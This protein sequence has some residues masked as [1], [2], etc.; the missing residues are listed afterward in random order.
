MWNR[1]K[2]VANA[3]KG[4][5]GG[6]TLQYGLTSSAP[7]QPFGEEFGL[8]IIPMYLSSSETSSIRKTVADTLSRKSGD[9]KVS[10]GRFQLPAFPKDVVLPIV[11][12][13]ERQD[14]VPSGWL[15]NQTANLYQQGDFIRSHVDNL[16]VYDDVFAIAS[17]GCNCL[18]KFVHVQNGEELE[19]VIPDGS[20]YILSG[21][22]RYVYF[23]M[24][25]PCEGQRI[26]LVM[27]RSILQSEGT[28]RVTNN[29]LSDL[30]QYRSTALLN[31]LYSKQIGGVRINVDDAFMEEENLGAFDTAQWVK[32]LRPL[33]DWTLKQQLDEDEARLKEMVAKGYLDD[34]LEWRVRELRSYFEGMEEAMRLGK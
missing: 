28:F 5:M 18:M 12:R 3:L 17:V 29:P 8:T 20:V 13:L 31:A 11:E 2:V 23:H 6:S 26:S 24:V 19:A 1:A 7:Y 27:R 21:P 9:V 15:N 22:A 14:F 34:G 16:F 25:M 33:K 4:V 32:K 10:D 30:M